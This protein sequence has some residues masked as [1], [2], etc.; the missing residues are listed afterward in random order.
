M[1]KFYISTFGCRVNQY[2]SEAIR[3]GWENNGY[4]QVGDPRLANY[5][6]INSCAITSRAEAETRNIINHYK[7]NFPQAKIILTGCSANRFNLFKSRKNTFFALPDFCIE[8][9]K[10]HILLSGAPDL[11]NFSEISLSN[12]LFFIKDYE[13]S[14]PVIKIQDGCNQNC[15]FCIV[16]LLRG[17]SVSR[18]PKEIL[19]ECRQLLN[20]GFSELV[21]SGINLKQY[22][23][24]NFD[25]WDLLKYLE[26]NLKNEIEHEWRLRLSSLE[27]G[28][29][30]S[31]ALD[32]IAQ[33]DF[34]SPHLHLSLQ[35][36]SE[37]ILKMMKRS[38]T[39]LEN[40]LNRI[41]EVRKFWPDMA[42]GADLILGFPGETEHDFKILLEVIDEIKLTYGHIFP[43]SRRP[44]TAAEIFS[45]QISRAVK[46]ERAKI[47][48]QKI[49]ELKFNYIKRQLNLTNTKVIFEK[50]NGKK[51]S[52]IYDADKYEIKGI[53]EF[54]ISC[55]LIGGN[56]DNKVFNNKIINCRPKEMRGNSLIVE[57][58]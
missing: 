57:P 3:E 56:S 19:S 4:T 32:I 40:L 37:K 25:L 39:N 10:K 30:H 26:D 18:N 21:I 52:N 6:I 34:L 27:P 43:Y 35:H 28:L 33:S 41:G 24:E 16:P 5:I 44:G 15:S 50:T 38:Y 36:G 11:I 9:S 42:L 29:L 55:L 14:R 22:K 51:I 20:N 45:N 54:Y 31:K 13:R 49:S 58:I 46:N 17:K 48:R 2:E 12:N 47:T 1:K 53:N 23:N 8:A 7:K